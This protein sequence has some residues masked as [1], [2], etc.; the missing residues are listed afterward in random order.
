MIETVIAQSSQWS[1]EHRSIDRLL[2]LMQESGCHIYGAGGFGREVAAAAVAKGIKIHGFI[3]SFVKAGAIVDGYACSSPDDVTGQTA[4]ESTLIIAVNNFKVEVAGIEQWAQQAGFREII[5]VPDLPDLISPSLGHYWQA[6]RNHPSENR[7]HLIELEAM[8]ADEA[9][10][11][12]LRQ[13]IAYRITGRPEDHPTVD[14]DHQYFPVDLPLPAGELNV[15]DCGAFPGDIIESVGRAG[16]KLGNWYA[17]EPDPENFKTLSKAAQAADCASASLFP[18]GVGNETGSVTFSIG[19]AD[20]SRA[21]TQASH[22]GTVV[23]VPIVRVGDVV[24]ANSIDFVK[25]DIE[26]FEAQAIEGMLNILSAHKPRV[27]V[28]IYHKPSD[29]WEIPMQLKR[30]FPN[31]RFAIRQHGY[32]GYDTVLYADLEG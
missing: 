7:S 6:S 16:L 22:Q 32:N 10:K 23:S 20:A 21:V 24:K 17:F 14:R 26:G 2:T 5:Y 19:N 8:L 4:E 30:H 28:A 27:A 3:D 12:Q 9:S 31:A 11:L 1:S 15:I 18:C 25:L 13:L 29:L